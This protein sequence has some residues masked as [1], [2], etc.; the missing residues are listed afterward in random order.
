MLF[1]YY[2]VTVLSGIQLAVHVSLPVRFQQGSLKLFNH[3][4]L[5]DL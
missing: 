2:V 1:V 3:T 4:F 5:T